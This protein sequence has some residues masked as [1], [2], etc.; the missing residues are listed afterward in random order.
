MG[1]FIARGHGPL[2]FCGKHFRGPE[3]SC[4]KGF[5]IGP[6][7]ECPTLSKLDHACMLKGVGGQSISMSISNRPRS[8]R[9]L[10]SVS[11]D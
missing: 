8:E 2:F 10:G 11:I 5:K 3:T 6:L 4:P 7:L 9:N 1:H